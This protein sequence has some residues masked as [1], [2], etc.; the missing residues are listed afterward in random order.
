[1]ERA[2][3][4]ESTAQHVTREKIPQR[5]PSRMN[6]ANRAILLNLLG[7]PLMALVIALLAHWLPVA[8]Y[9]TRAQRK[10]TDL[11]V[12]GA[13]LYP[14]LFAGCNLLLLPGGVL[15]IG[16]GLFFGLWW[17]WAFNVLGSTLGA[18]AAL[19][20]ARRFGRRWVEARLV[21]NGKWRA[22]D[23]AVAREGWKIIFLSQVH[24]LFPTSLLNYLYGVTRVP[25]RTCVLWI[26]LGQAPGMF[27][28]AYLGR[29]AQSGLRV[30]RGNG[31]LSAFDWALWC[32]GLVLAVAVTTA[33]ARLALRM[34]A[35]INENGGSPAKRETT[36]EVLSGQLR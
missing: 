21:G 8:E 5:P 34:L 13:V 35:G 17:G 15:A 4:T 16:S 3:R 30:W 36:P 31:S 23:A 22:L 20:I 24:P 11:E 14:L 25:I 12:W 32:A 6:R 29:M 2:A 26:A 19:L 18:T 9:V 10:I 33:L 7:L 28:Y 1:M 27:L